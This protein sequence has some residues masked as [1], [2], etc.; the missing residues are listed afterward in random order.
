MGLSRTT[1]IFYKG[2]KAIADK[3]ISDNGVERG[4]V[5][6]NSW[7]TNIRIGVLEQYME[8]FGRR[9]G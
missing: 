9:V 7:G 3:L 1:L 4:G 8:A 6:N 5:I 2:W